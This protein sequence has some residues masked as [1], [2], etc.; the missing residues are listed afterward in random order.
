MAKIISVFNH[1]GGVSKT[2]SVYHIGW[3]LANLGKKVILVDADSQCNLS[4]IAMGDANFETYCENN[5]KNIKSAISPVFEGNPIPI[6]A[7]S[8]GQI[9]DN[10]NLFLIPGS[11][12]LSEYEVSLGVSFTLSETLGTLKNLPGSLYALLNK[13]ANAINADYILIDLNPSL[14]AFNQAFFSSSDYFIIPA[15]PDKFS[16]MAIKSLS[17][18]LPKWEQWAI[19]ARDT[20]K[21][22]VY[23]LPDK[24]P[25]FLGT[26]MQ[27]FNIR[28]GEPTLANQNLIDNFNSV[29]MQEL[30][31]ALSTK[32]MLIENYN[33]RNYSLSLIPDFQTLNTKFQKYGYPV[34]SLTDSMLEGQGVVQNNYI[35][36][37]EEFNGIYLDLAQKII[38]NV[39]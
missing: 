22:V 37:R 2:T 32:D 13:T 31:P 27:R 21:D 11:F 39:E 5:N 36:K 17:K 20:F 19:L 1:K 4:S 38:S 34:F 12:E 6:E 16:L 30:V 18:I 33:I 24:K 15:A 14:S 8:C 25:K 23:P 9:K 26:I 35:Q 3:K 10:E 28:A 29:I 7:F